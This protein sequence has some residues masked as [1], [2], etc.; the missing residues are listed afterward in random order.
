MSSGYQRLVNVSFK[1]DADLLRE[2]DD[3]ARRRGMDRS[4]VIRRAV[5]WYLKA[6]N[7]PSITPRITIYDVGYNNTNNN[8]ITSRIRIR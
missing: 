3:Y 6:F 8:V 1:I 5:A 7:R 4:E 2:L